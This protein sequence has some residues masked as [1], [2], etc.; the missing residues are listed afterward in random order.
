MVKVYNAVTLIYKDRSKSGPLALGGGRSRSL[1][2]WGKQSRILNTVAMGGSENTSL[3]C[4]FEK[5][6]E[7]ETKEELMS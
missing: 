6:E 4:P 3:M 1:S 2:L 7:W 5:V